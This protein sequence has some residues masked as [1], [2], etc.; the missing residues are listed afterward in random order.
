MDLELLKVNWALAIAAMLGL[1]ILVIVIVQLIGRTAAGQL[2][3]KVKGLAEARLEE[4][5]AIQA[6]EKAERIATRLHEKSDDTKPR[7]LQEAKEALQDARALAK[8]ANDKVLV[9]QNH[10]RRIIHEEYPPKKQDKLRQKYL[11]AEERDTK[12]FSF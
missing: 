1:V 5:K 7:H 11:P 9:A 3:A 10:V 8:I 12:P 4:A 6:V 2:R